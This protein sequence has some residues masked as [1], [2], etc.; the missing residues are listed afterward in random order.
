MKE[1]IE[2]DRHYV[3]QFCSPTRSAL[4]SGRN[5]IHVN[6]QNGA[7][8]L[9]N[10]ADAVSGFAGIPRNMTGTPAPCYLPATKPPPPSPAP[11][12]TLPADTGMSSVT[13]MMAMMM[14]MAMAMA[15]ATRV[16]FLTIVLLT[17]LSPYFCHTKK[18]SPNT[19][20][21]VNT[22]PTCTES[23]IAGWR[24]QITHRT[25]EGTNT[26]WCTT[27]TSTMRGTAY[28]GTG[29]N[30]KETR[31]IVTVRVVQP[32]IRCSCCQIPSWYCSCRH[33]RHCPL[34]SAGFCSICA[35]VRNLCAVCRAPCDVRR[36]TCTVRCAMC[37]A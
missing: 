30:A 4:Q 33:R 6:T 5:P 29:L 23:G 21:A 26:R 22:K 35:D 19:C 27:T 10:A 15:I 16:F 1:G 36:V 9:H 13:M 34:E 37:A 14:T 31:Q 20:N 17:T 32:T 18:A 3:F 24:H 28:R 7:P 12:G 25:A 2:L 11:C 8:Q